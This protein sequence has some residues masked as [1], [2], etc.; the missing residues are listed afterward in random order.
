MIH[1]QEEG[2]QLTEAVRR[3]PHSVV[4]L[5]ELE[6]AHP[7]VLNILL[8]I[9]EDG[10][11]TDGKGRTV[12]FKNV[13]LVMTSNVGSKKILQLAKDREK[14]TSDEGAGATDT[15]ANGSIVSQASM[16][17]PKPEE[18]LNKL[19]KSPKA[20]AL[21]ME[22]SRDSDIMSAMQTAMGGSPAD[23]MKVAQNNPK[24]ADFLTRL[25]D[26]LEMDPNS[27]SGSTY[28]SSNTVSETQ[29]KSGLES[30]RDNVQATLEGW[31][32]TSLT[33]GNEFTSGLINQLNGMIQ[34]DRGAG[35]TMGAS[36]NNLD[37]EIAAQEYTK[38]SNVV[39]EELEEVIKP[40][41]LNRIDE[42]IIFAP[43]GSSDL[44]S[45]AQLIIDQTSK[46]AGKERKIDISVGPRLL[47]K[48]VDD[49]SS[50]A[51]QFGARPMRRAVQRY[52]EDTTSD[53]I[54]RGFIQDFDVVKV[55]LD[56]SQDNWVRIT[57]EKDGKSISSRVE[58][59]N[60]GIGSNVGKRN[61]ID[62]TLKRENDR[63]ETES[64][65][66]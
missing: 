18:V 58:D 34:S 13:I 56:D 41:V 40:E 44:H 66:N 14:N 63:L 62:E 53:A 3:A 27:S 16:E 9:L 39:K 4:L 11:L 33:S 30:I 19:Q 7:D 35:N 52:F 47:E 10:I 6:K 1:L 49:G 23:L 64:I 60:G 37:E 57:R 48:I 12:N 61:S 22:A 50:N 31:S 25:W 46:R 2:G 54:I 26:A 28:E 5:D 65:Y 24:V 15:L 43:L 45:I 42:I 20:M 51:A 55:E 32:K 21:M 17:P 59:A 38:M 36:V 29:P 8:Q